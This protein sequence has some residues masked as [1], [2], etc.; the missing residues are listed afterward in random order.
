MQVR[1]AKEKGLLFFF[2]RFFLWWSAV[3]GVHLGGRTNAVH[4]PDHTPGAAAMGLGEGEKKGICEQAEEVE[5]EFAFLPHHRD[6]SPASFLPII[7]QLGGRDG[8]IPK[9]RDENPILP[10]VSPFF[11]LSLHRWKREIEKNALFPARLL[12]IPPYSTPPSG[13]NKQKRIFDPPSRPP[14]I[15]SGVGDAP[16]SSS[17]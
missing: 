1:N 5:A 9:P 17:K 12:P 6:N 10:T 8:C 3:K 2:V 7:I 13:G 14:R 15:W 4:T 11:E 16:F